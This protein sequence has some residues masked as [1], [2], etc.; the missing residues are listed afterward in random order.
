VDIR[1]VPPAAQRDENAVQILSAWIAE[2]GLHCSLK[3]GMR[4]DTDHN[5]AEAWGTL[6]ADVVRHIANAMREEY[7]VDPSVTI[8]AIVDSLLEEVD[9][10]SSEAR[11]GFHPGT[12]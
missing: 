6:L 7:G 3:I 1:V 8:A 5:E 11:G 12:N 9:E 2:D 10:P 4:K